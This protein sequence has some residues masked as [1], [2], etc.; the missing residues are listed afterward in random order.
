MEKPGPLRKRAALLA[1][2][3][4]ELLIICVFQTQ[5]IHW[6]IT[7]F[8]STIYIFHAP[9]AHSHLFLLEVAVPNLLWDK[10]KA[11]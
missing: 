7:T 1:V 4:F 2:I 10:S 3:P 11:G 8:L 9:A 5:H 6:L